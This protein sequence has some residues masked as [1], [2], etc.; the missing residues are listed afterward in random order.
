[1][2]C[3]SCGF[4]WV[5]RPGKDNFTNCPVCKA[6]LGIKAD[7]DDISAGKAVGTIIKQYGID[8]LTQHTRF[9]ERFNALAPKLTYERKLLAMAAAGDALRHFISSGDKENNAVISEVKAEL[10]GLLTSDAVD[11]L[12]GIFSEALGWNEAIQ[13]KAVSPAPAEKE[14]SAETVKAPEKTAP[15]E[16][17]IPD[18]VLPKGAEYSG[19]KN[20][21]GLPHG[22]GTMTYPDGN[23]YEGEWKNGQ[24]T[25]KGIMK[26]PSGDVYEGGWKNGKRSGKGV[27]KYSSGD[28]YDGSWKNDERSGKGI[29]RYSNG[30]VYEGEWKNDDLDGMGKMEFRNGDIYTGNFKNGAQSGYGRMFYINGDNYDGSWRLN[31]RY[32]QGIMYYKNGDK[33]EGEWNQDDRHGVGSFTHNGKVK[34]GVWEND[35]FKTT[36]ILGKFI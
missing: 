25:G 23:V 35:E 36:S 9:I 3:Q 21:A 31:K 30:N 7:T 6:S 4:E 14:R 13:E 26:Y 19:D 10:E 29:M 5:D 27:M 18:N 16:K 24:R 20:S 11:R 17:N 28:V 34:K 22:N 1:M 32:G 2:K 15:A 33:Y 12:I 8:I